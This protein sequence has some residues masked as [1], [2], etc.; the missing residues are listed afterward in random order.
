MLIG[1]NIYRIKKD[2]QQW[3]QWHKIHK[4]DVRNG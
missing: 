4:V 1:V 2:K 3:K